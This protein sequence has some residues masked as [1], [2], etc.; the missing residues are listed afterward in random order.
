MFGF[1]RLGRFGWFAY[2][3]LTAE[4]AEAG[5]GNFGLMD[6]LAALRGVHDNIAAFGGDPARVTLFGE[7]AGG[8]SVNALM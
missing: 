8:I 3:E 7:S 2:P 4:A 5:T 6:Q 1:S